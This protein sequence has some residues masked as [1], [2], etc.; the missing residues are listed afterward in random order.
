MADFPG[1]LTGTA[2][3][4]RAEIPG[5]AEEA[6]YLPTTL[7]PEDKLL[8]DEPASLA[9]PLGGPAVD[10]H[11]EPTPTGTGFPGMEGDASTPGLD[12]Y[13]RFHVLPRSI[14]LGNV[15]TTTTVQ[16]EVFSAFR[17]DAQF[18]TAF[19]N[20]AGSG[21]SLVGGPTLPVLVQPM[22]GFDMQVQVDLSGPAVVDG[23]LDFTFNVTGL[24]QVPI[25]FQRVVLLQVPP[26]MP[27]EE[28]LE[29]L[30]DVLAKADGTEQRRAIRKNPRQLFQWD[31]LVDDGPERS[32]LENVL[33]DWQSR[34]FGLPVWHE[35]TP[36][37]G[38]V[39]AAVTTTFSVVSTA[40]ADYRD[41]ELVVIWESPTKFDVL[42]LVSHT[43][44]TLTVLNPPANSYA[45]V[46]DLVLVAP[47]RLG[48]ADGAVR[49]S[50]YLQG[51]DRFRL[52][53]RVKDNDS[54]LASTSGWSTFNSKVLLDDSN[55]VE[56]QM[57]EEYDHPVI[58]IDGGAGLTQEASRQD[59]HRR[60]SVRRFVV[61]T[62]AGLWRVRRLL[63]AFRGRQVSFYLPTFSKDL[64][65]IA[66]MTSGQTVLSVQNVGYTNFVRSRQP[67][68][69]I[70]VQPVTGAAFLRTIT[71]SSVISSTQEN[72]TVDSSWPSTLTPAQIARVSFVE[73][74]RGDSDQ[75]RIQHG[76]GTRRVVTMPVRTVLE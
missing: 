41:G 53:F 71:G 24:I 21:V 67:K 35:A 55:F 60:A 72:I 10:D 13:E 37:T 69:V 63:H 17:D 36:L 57:P 62:K 25:S 45:P 27:Y 6:Y 16:M 20:N 74:V 19:D 48:V 51:Q 47:L 76:R 43:A 68:N 46:A 65:P 32:F 66:T 75:I 44:T 18:W 34:T 15:L 4:V 11:A 61:S 38:S 40:D 49:G 30:T 2:T 1:G 12:F 22:A 59:R 54:D 70:Q 31:L 42:N 39:T 33:F 23:T 9:A 5:R 58:R 7:V 26:E 29:W 64:T 14:D 52:R 28:T 73:K 3:V 56:G 8:L 50:R